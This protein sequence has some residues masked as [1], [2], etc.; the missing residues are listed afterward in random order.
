MVWPKVHNKNVVEDLLKHFNIPY[1]TGT[2]VTTDRQT[3]WASWIM[4]ATLLPYLV[5]QIP[6]LF[7]LD[8]GGHFCIAVAAFISVGGL[9]AY[10]TYQVLDG[11]HSSWFICN[12]FGSCHLF[13]V[14]SLYN[15]LVMF[16]KCSALGF[17][18]LFLCGC[19]FTRIL[20]KQ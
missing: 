8:T 12:W 3:Q 11:Y 13:Q 7:G 20:R 4:I 16:V 18:R 15:I 1:S 9:V 10:C 14:L 6:R 2:G 19:D 5:A 17:G